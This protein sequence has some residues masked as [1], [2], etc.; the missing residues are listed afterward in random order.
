MRLLVNLL[1]QTGDAAGIAVETKKPR[2]LPVL[3]LLFA[4]LAVRVSV[5]PSPVQQT[6]TRLPVFTSRLN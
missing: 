4:G 2:H 3:V 6:S 1:K 5:V